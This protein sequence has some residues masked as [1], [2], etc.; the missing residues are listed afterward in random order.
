MADLMYA[1]AR[2]QEGMQFDVRTGSGHEITV[3]ASAD[4]GGG[5]A[6]PRPVGLLLVANATCMG[7]DVVSILQ[8]MRQ[9]VKAYTLK[10]T[11]ERAD[12]HPRVF[13]HILIEHVLEG[14]VDEAKLAHAIE[15]SEEKYCS[16]SAML[17][18]V[19][20]IETRYVVRK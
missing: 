15:L 12:D 6:G 20:R 4:H 14:Q 8:K 3:D 10:V 18:K 1:E 5:D 7:M 9:E 19:A 13:T 17:N 11:G 2:W 16:V